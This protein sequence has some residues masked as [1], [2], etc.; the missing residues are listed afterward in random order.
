M[1]NSNCPSQCTKYIMIQ[2]KVRKDS[3]ESEPVYM[4]CDS[5]FLQQ[6]RQ[7]LKWNRTRV[8]M[9]RELC[10]HDSQIWM[11]SEFCLNDGNV[12]KWNVLRVFQITVVRVRFHVNVPLK[13][14]PL[15]CGA[16]NEPHNDLSFTLDLLKCIHTR[17]IE[18]GCYHWIFLFYS[19][20]AYQCGRYCLLNAIVAQSKNCPFGWS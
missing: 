12:W 8:C 7:T 4:Q 18:V 11:L 5:H 10:P 15:P 19:W 2:H 3:I 16:K 9:W 6:T 17:T 13:R 20:I 14:I 1:C